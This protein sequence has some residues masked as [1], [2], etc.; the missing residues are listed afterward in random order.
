LLSVV[1]SEQSVKRKWEGA[2]LFHPRLGERALLHRGRK[3]APLKIA[4]VRHPNFLKL[5]YGEASE[6]Q[7]K[8]FSCGNP[9]DHNNWGAALFTLFVKGAGSNLALNASREAWSP[10][11]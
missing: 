5:I 8:K 10:P 2:V 9:P 3:P 4:R 1:S 6:W 11:K 7:P